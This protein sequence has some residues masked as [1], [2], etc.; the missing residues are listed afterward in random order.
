MDLLQ[1]EESRFDVDTLILHDGT[2]SPEVLTEAA[3]RAAE[4]GTVLVA[5]QKPDGRRWNRLI[6]YEKGEQVC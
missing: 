6:Q 1:G 4:T 3:A 2:V 5:R